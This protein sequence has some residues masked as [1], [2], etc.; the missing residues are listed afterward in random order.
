MLLSK[1]TIEGKI[2]LIF[3]LR[4]INSPFQTGVILIS[5][6]LIIRA[7]LQIILQCSY[8]TYSLTTIAFLFAVILLIAALIENQCLLIIYIVRFIKESH[9]SFSKTYF[10]SLLASSTQ[11]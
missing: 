4:K 6:Y 2:N 9:S 7:A 10:D 1:V 5:S 8:W 11:L 3:Y